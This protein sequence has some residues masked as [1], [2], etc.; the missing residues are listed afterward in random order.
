MFRFESRIGSDTCLTMLF[1]IAL[2]SNLGDRLE[3]LRMARRMLGNFGKDLDWSSIYQTEPVD[4]PHDSGHFYNAVG[5]IKSTLSPP[6]LLAELQAMEARMGRAAAQLREKNAP[7]CIDIDIMFAGDLQIENR[8]LTI[9]HPRWHE[10]RFV[11]TPLAELDADAIHTGQTATVREILAALPADGEPECLRVCGP[12]AWKPDIAKMT[13]TDLAHWRQRRSPNQQL[14]SLTAYDY[15]TARI[16]DEAGVDVILV[17]DSLGMVFAG[18]PNTTGVSMD[19][20]LYHTEVVRR[21]ITQALLV[22][23]L[24]YRSYEDVPSTVENARRLIDAG[25]DL[26][27]LEG[28]SGQKHKI[29]ALTAAGIPTVGHLGML[30]QRVVEEGGYRKKGKSDEDAERLLK[31]ASD[32]EGA[33][34]SA[35]VLESVVAEVAKRITSQVSV[36]TIGIGSGNDCDGQIR[37]INDL[38]G[39]YPWFVPPFASTYADFAGDLRRAVARFR[40]E[41]QVN[42]Q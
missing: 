35:I 1:T 11:L 15:P 18:L 23:D 28:G 9:P 40:E 2:G 10:R 7:R 3:N 38:V 19:H 29:E 41:I 25:A 12:D 21:G 14:L 26:V 34:V 30:P 8:E 27:K 31:G 37:V 22:S 13:P 20:M 32:L 33:G 36:P 6:R 42:R 24:P 16:L 4:C 17:G 39:S 5:I